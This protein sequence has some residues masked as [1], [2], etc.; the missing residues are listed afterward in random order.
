MNNTAEER[1]E[2]LQMIYDHP[3]T[4]SIID[5]SYNIHWKKP[6][7]NIL[8]KRWTNK[9]TIMDGGFSSRHPTP[10]ITITDWVFFPLWSIENAPIIGPFAGA[11]LDFISITLANTGIMVGSMT[12]IVE[13][14]RDPVLQAAMSAFSVGTAG[15]G[16]AAT[17]VIVPIVN[18]VVDLLV[19]MTA[20]S[21]D[22][23]NMFYNIN[24][25]NFG[26]SYLLF[27]EIIPPL[28]ELMDKIINYTVI[29]NRSIKRNVRFVDM[30]IDYIDIYEETV[31]T[32]IHPQVGIYK[33]LKP[34]SEKVNRVVNIIEQLPTNNLPVIAN[35]A[36]I[37]KNKT[38]HILKKIE[39]NI[40]KLNKINKLNNLNK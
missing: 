10:E 23:I 27:M 40:N 15:V 31:K 24:R 34:Y 18:R 6:I 21:I 25:K 9:V 39:V 12:K 32:L 37:L 17:P 1:K 4:Q 36:N 33:L 38:I 3:S 19:H 11:P 22:I 13:S 35:V 14:V 29:F 28:N 7:E 2:I 26:L 20:H 5:K 30:F 8:K 16:L